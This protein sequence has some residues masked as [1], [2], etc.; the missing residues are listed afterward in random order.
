MKTIDGVSVEEDV[1]FGTGGGRD[2]CCDVYRSKSTSSDS[3]AALLFHG[4]GWKYGSKDALQDQAVFLANEG[5]VAVTPEY[6][7]AAESRWPAHIHDTKAA[8]RWLRA[9]VDQLGVDDSKIAAVGFSSGAHLALLAT[10]TPGHEPFRGSGGHGEVSEDL[11]AVVG[12]YTPV[13]FRMEGETL[14]GATAADHLALDLT[15]EEAITA[16]PL[17]YATSDFPPTMLL[18]GAADD[19]VPVEAT[20]RMY[21]ALDEQNV[22]IDLHLYGGLAH[23]FPR[24]P[25]MVHE[26]MTEVASFLERVMVAPDRYPVE[27]LHW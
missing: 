11:N 10:G 1:V 15:A 19:L 23:G 3:P 14:S 26:T 22:T 27:D 20:L 4:G 8:I 7:L 25:G 18:H 9:S 5:F 24:L 17:S 21:E 16:A 6:R 2:L 13:C 12:F